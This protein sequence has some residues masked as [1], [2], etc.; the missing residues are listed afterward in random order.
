MSNSHRSKRFLASALF[1]SVLCLYLCSELSPRW[2]TNDDVGL[3]MIAHGFG[4]IKTSSP[5]LMFSN[6]I[7]GY[8][9]RAIPPI[10][11]ILGYSI[12]L[13]L[14]NCLSVV[15]I[16]TAFLIF[17]WGML[18]S[19]SLGA[20]ILLRL[21]ISPQFTVSAG[22]LAI[23]ALCW[24]EVYKRDHRYGSLLFS[25]FLVFLSF[26]IRSNETVL[27]FVTGFSFF[28]LVPT[29]LKKKLLIGGIFLFFVLLTAERWNSLQ[30]NNPAWRDYNET[31]ETRRKMIDFGWGNK[32]KEHRNLL[33]EKGL[34]ENDVTLYEN[35]F[36]GDLELKESKM[37][38]ELLKDHRT[39][40]R[41]FNFNWARG[42]DWLMHFKNMGP[43]FLTSCVFFFLVP[44]LRLFFLWIA[45]LLSLFVIGTSGK[46]AVFRVMIPLQYLLLSAPFLLS[47]KKPRP[48]QKAVSFLVLFVCLIFEARTYIRGTTE[49]TK[50]VFEISKSLTELENR[51]IVIWGGWFPFEEAFPVLGKNLENKKLQLMSLGSSTL[52]PNSFMN[53]S[54][55]NGGT[56]KSLLTSSEGLELISSDY[57]LNLLKVFC[58]EHLSSQLKILNQQWNGYFLIT[59]IRC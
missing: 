44:S 34:S 47:S 45:T 8:F 54:F 2:E 50:R 51:R 59:K 29:N 7:W 48:S 28:L 21:I 39:N 16:V 24:I 12:A 17:D 55:K 31:F 19:F 58:Q 13:I 30:Y 43:L 41:L 46:P 14:A 33:F 26:V 4:I 36:L 18:I 5:L 56:I 42:L 53:H 49:R 9:V 37:I 57:E 32:L 27:V 11:G 15:S 35:W 6:V 52:N 1:T 38:A 3:S 40:F 10:N 25:F 20:I 22:V 23:S